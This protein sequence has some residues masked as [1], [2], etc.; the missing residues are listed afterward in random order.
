MMHPDEI[1]SVVIR[2]GPTQQRFLETLA[3]AWPPGPTQVMNNL[4]L[5]TA[6]ARYR[7][8]Q[9]NEPLPLPTDVASMALFW[10]RLWDTYQPEQTQRYV[11]EQ[12]KRFI[13]LYPEEIHE[14][15]LITYSGSLD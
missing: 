11:A 13:T 9:T 10:K 8:R 12:V 5:A 3:A 4:T 6:L 15:D 7:Y 2:M 14:R 1:S